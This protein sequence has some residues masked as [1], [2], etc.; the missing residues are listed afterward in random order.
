[1]SGAHIDQGVQTEVESIE[2]KKLAAQW[3]N[4]EYTERKKNEVLKNE[5]MKRIKET[6]ELIE[7]AEGKVEVFEW[8]QLYDL[9]SN[10]IEEYT[11]NVDSTLNR[12]DKLY[13][14]C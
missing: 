5:I 8:D 3:Q 11:K 4:E 10:I 1:M 7:K 9:S 2:F 6:T 14:V 13:H 12:L